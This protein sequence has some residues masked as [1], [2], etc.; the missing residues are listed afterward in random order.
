M[1]WRH[2]EGKEKEEGHHEA[3]ETHGLGQGKP[4]DGVGEQLLL[5]TRVSEKIK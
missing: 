3:E 5:Q 2:L 4:Q 1:C